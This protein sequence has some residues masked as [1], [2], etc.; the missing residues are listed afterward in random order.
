MTTAQ[1]INYYKKSLS[2]S[3]Q[4]SLNFKEINIYKSDN[5]GC[6][7]HIKS[8]FNNASSSYL[9]TIRQNATNEKKEKI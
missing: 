2:I 8:L 9:A 3:Q 4:S 1:I 5:D 6:H 7:K